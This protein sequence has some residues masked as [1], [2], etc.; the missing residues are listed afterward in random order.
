MKRLLQILTIAVF[1]PMASFAQNSLFV[2]GVVTSDAGPIANTMVT[3]MGPSTPVMV[4]DTIDIVYTDENGM[5]ESDNDLEIAY[6]DISVFADGCNNFAYFPNLVYPVE[7]AVALLCDGGTGGG[8]DCAALFFY[9]SD[10]V[11][12]GT[13]FFENASSGTDLEYLWY[14]GDGNQ[15][16]EANPTHTYADADAE[17]DVCLTIFTAT[18][19]NTY[20]T[21]VSGADN[22]GNTGSGDGCEA[23]FVFIPDSVVD[24]T[25]YYINASIGTDLEYL[26]DFGDGFES[27]DPYPTHTYAD[28]DAEYNVCLTVFA[29]SCV[30]TYCTIV[31]GTYDGDPNGPGFAGDGGGSQQGKGIGEGFI[32]VVQTNT[33]TGV[34][35]NLK[36]V[37]FNIY[38]NPST[39][40]VNIN[41][42]IQESGSIMIV[43][44][45][46]KIV[47]QENN[48]NARNS[49]LAL[50]ALN[51]GIYII[52]F[53]SL[54]F[55]STSKL[56]LQ[57]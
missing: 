31:S 41:L 35:E 23:L 8:D 45:S 9:T 28:A 27:T 25:I 11:S 42:D 3:I 36:E 6:T 50:D 55:I 30:S 37:D 17:Y 12:D 43:D 48:I 20:C 14:F 5:F 21:T 10:S 40:T 22:G 15:S 34:K 53:R 24:G 38:P 47:Y 1:I 13:V 57:R 49:A 19:Q 33:V 44:L 4:G 18:C 52:Q 39:G 51:D 46:G 54:N 56:I 32:F 7:L 2:T 16:S 26:W 29:D